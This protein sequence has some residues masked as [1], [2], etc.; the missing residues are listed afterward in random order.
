MHWG[1]IHT[2]S[3]DSSS[4]SEACSINALFP[5]LYP[6]Q[7]CS[8]QT[9]DREPYTSGNTKDSFGLMSTNPITYGTNNSSLDTQT[10]EALHFGWE[11]P[12]DRLKICSRPDGSD[13]KLGS[14]GFGTV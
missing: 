3:I 5:A 7:V 8:G 11:I 14:G 6:L 4:P 2:G 10:K 12:P 13:M 1:D 9:C